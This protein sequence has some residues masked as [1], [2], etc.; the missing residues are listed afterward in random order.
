LFT[1]VDEQGK[2]KE[3]RLTVLQKTLLIL[4]NLTN[5]YMIMI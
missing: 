5:N 1:T 4:K 2:K 3:R